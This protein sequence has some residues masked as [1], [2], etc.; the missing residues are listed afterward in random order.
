MTN[1]GR[2]GERPGTLPAGANDS[3]CQ[4]H[5]ELARVHLAILWTNPHRQ[6]Q[7]M[8]GYIYDESTRFGSII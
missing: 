1:L 4:T 3:N 8:A 5:R 6:H 2:S 7:H